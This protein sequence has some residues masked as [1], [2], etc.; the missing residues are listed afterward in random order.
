M[1]STIQH[2]GPF[3]RIYCI[4]IYSHDYHKA[5]LCC[6][7]VWIKKKDRLS[8]QQFG[9][10]CCLRVNIALC[11]VSRW[12]FCVK[13]MF[14]LPLNDESHLNG[15]SKPWTFS[16]HSL[17]QLGILCGTQNAQLCL[18]A[19]II[20]LDGSV[21]H[22]QWIRHDWFH[23]TGTLVGKQWEAQSHLH[24]MHWQQKPAFQR[25]RG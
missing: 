7:F 22:Q 21:D 10:R 8:G 11:L 2:S 3:I 18:E 25:K 17:P 19:L 4:S 15:L 6:T 23:E 16:P 13:T 9:E 14:P 5:I 24:Y 12:C 1:S 20:A